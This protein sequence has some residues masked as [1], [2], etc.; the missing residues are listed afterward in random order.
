MY[1]YDILNFNKVDGEYWEDAPF[2]LAHENHYTIEEFN[3]MVQEAYIKVLKEDNKKWNKII[4]ATVHELI[5]NKGFHATVPEGS[6]IFIN[7]KFTKI[8][9]PE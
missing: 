2:I 7:D 4:N 1:R 8:E 5:H 6:A 3:E 9:F